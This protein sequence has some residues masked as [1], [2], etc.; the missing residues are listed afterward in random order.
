MGHKSVGIFEVEVFNI[1]LTSPQ[2]QLMQHS[3]TTIITHIDINNAAEYQKAFYCIR[4]WQEVGKV[5][6]ITVRT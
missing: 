6:S 1:R 2:L 3:T 4:P 5:A